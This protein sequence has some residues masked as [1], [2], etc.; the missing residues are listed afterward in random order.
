MATWLERIGDPRDIR[1]LSVEQLKEIADEIRE[2]IL[3]VTATNGGHL[4]SSL[5]VVE[6]TLALHHVFDTPRD[7]I[8]WDVGHQGYA[9]KLLTGR[10]DRFHTI[11][12]EGGL[13]G[14]LKRNESPYDAFGAG[15]ASTAMSAAVG[16]AIA[17]DHK[18][19]DYRVVS[20]TG[21]G[22][23]SGGICYEAL[24]NAGMLKTNLLMILNDNKMS[25]SPNVGALA[26]YFNRMI[27]THFYNEKRRGAI[28][29]IKRLPAGE[30][31]LHLTN[32]VEESVKGLIVP[33]IFFEEL[34]V[35][36][37]GPVDGHNLEEL[38]PTLRKVQTFPGPILLHVIT[39]KG[40]GRDYSEADPVTF[41]SPPLHFDA[42]SGEAPAVEPGAARVYRCLRRGSA[43]TK[44][45]A[46]SVLWPSRQ[47][48]SRALGSCASRKSSPSGLT[49]WGSPKST[50]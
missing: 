20:V 48:C 6:L 7:R 28:E 45:A 26:H 1:G 8:V 24:N 35:R 36:Y 22:A 21:D 13:S 3:R 14:F 11:R 19:E 4:A 23:M 31:F 46:T 25:I 40:K 43:G 29:L 2:I 16:M 50:P 12:K 41:H 30:R 34:G 27:T 33:G 9:H 37:L 32:R 42:D 15:H 5:G 39:V 44:P 10:A 47:P 49:T 17:R 38:I 18:G